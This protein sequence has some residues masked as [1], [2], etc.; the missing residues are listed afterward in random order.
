M[1]SEWRGHGWYLAPIH[2]AVFIFNNIFF[3]VVNLTPTVTICLYVFSYLMYYGG[4]YLILG[5]SIHHKWVIL[6]GSKERAFAQY[7]VY[8][9][10]Y[11]AY[12]CVYIFL[13]NIALL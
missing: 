6:A 5:S 8:I 12:I 10:V 13:I 2:I 4:N 1:Y 3:A 11:S 7:E 9:Y